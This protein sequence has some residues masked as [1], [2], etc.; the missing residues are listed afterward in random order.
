MW[1]RHKRIPRFDS[2]DTNRFLRVLADPGVMSR[3]YPSK[4]VRLWKGQVRPEKFH[5]YFFDD[6]KLEPDRVRH[7]ILQA[8]GG[9]PAKRSGRLPPGHNTKAR[10]EKL[11]LPDSVRQEIAK[12]FREEL[13]ECAT[14]LG[15][16]ATQWPS[17]YGFS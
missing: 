6:L 5:L 14:E 13:E 2:T 9:D 8:L 16:R 12:F 4:I 3:S 7:S 10:L 15:G 1:V 17:R 11:P